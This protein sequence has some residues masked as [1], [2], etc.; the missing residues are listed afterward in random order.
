[1]H[2]EIQK[3]AK[4]ALLTC[5]FWVDD[6]IISGDNPQLF[7][8][9]FISIIHKHGYSVRKKKVKVMSGGMFQEVT[10]LGVNR[11]IKVPKEKIKEYERNILNFKENNAFSLL[12]GSIEGQIQYVKYINK[13]QGDKIAK[14]KNKIIEVLN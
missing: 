3:I 2:D 10:G 14:F 6:I 11:G 13:K 5:T 8:S 4:K 1:M 12:L 9:E 7:L